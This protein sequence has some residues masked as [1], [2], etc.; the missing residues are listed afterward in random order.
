MSAQQPLFAAF[1]GART[2]VT[3]PVIKLRKLVEFMGPAHG[4]V[5]F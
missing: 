1:W 5:M 2:I 4:E 3:D